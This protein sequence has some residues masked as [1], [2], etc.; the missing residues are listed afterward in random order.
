MPGTRV[1]AG[2]LP[3]LCLLAVTS[4]STLAVDEAGITLGSVSGPGWSVEDI[5]LHTGWPQAGQVSM[6]LTAA[7]ADLPEPLGRITGLKLTC[8]ALQFDSETLRCPA[9]T[10]EAQSSQ[11]GRQRIATSFHYRFSD[12]RLDA[13][14]QDIRYLGGRLALAARYTAG[15][16]TLDVDGR[17]LSL[18]Q[19]TAQAGRL[20][21]PL[22]LLEGDGELALTASLRGAGSEI[23]AADVQTRVQGAG[24]SNAAGSIA[25][26]DVDLGI[27]VQA[28]P[29]TSGWHVQVT[30]RAE[31]GGYYVEPVYLAIPERPVQA[32]A[33]LDWLAQRKVLVLHELDYRHPGCIQLAA[34]G[35]IGLAGATQ[36]TELEVDVQEAAL[37][38][39][40]TSYLQ[41]W[42]T[43]T[44]AGRL[45]ASGVLSGRLVVR[46]NAPVTAQLKLQ[47]V[48]LDEQD[49]LFGFTGLAG[50]LDWSDTQ[51][52]EY[53]ELSWQDGH[54]YRIALGPVQIEAESVGNTV[55]LV[56]PTG[57]PV[58]D[59][60]LQIDS[61]DLAHVAGKPLRWHVDGLLTPV[62]MKQLTAALDWPEFG[63]KLS[64]VIP[65]VR[66]ED[67]KLEVGGVLLVRVFDGVVT[68]RNLQLESPLGLVPRLQV[69]ARIDKVD[70]EQLTRTFSF[71]RIEGRLD[72][73][74]DG[75][76]MESWRPVAF[77]AEFAT[78]EDDRSRHRISQKAV[79]NISNIGGGGVGGAVSRSFLRFLEDFPYD[80]LGIRCR[81]ENGVCD[82]GGVEPAQQGYYL[83]KG[84][85]IPPRLDVVGY[86]KRVNWN[87]LVAQIIS[88][89]GKQDIVVE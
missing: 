8:P 67:G 40:Y 59:G 88:V 10:L 73:R 45:T 38:P 74:I 63:G 27:D 51:T 36:V 11:L 43:G 22:P 71:G 1:I 44:P 25:G 32:T 60:T 2:L 50:N 7:R 72:G 30:V 35:R 23:T 20:G 12:G 68:L 3:V 58:L 70:L 31:R 61:F 16:W 49:G 26:E 64:G 75:L 78:P 39:L 42:L 6:L 87:S 21:Y 18:Q 69:D 76:R 57:I 82:M 77:D 62:S 17:S 56:R 80:R 15:G 37:G 66:Y 65:S 4:L 41:P 54:V 84:R 19:V 86:A 48:V 13:R 5:A 89:T 29:Y 47:D 85:F 24:I 81:L 79:D 33:R 52:P 53:S 83:V 28:R 34:R 46:D 55:K 14:L 9:G